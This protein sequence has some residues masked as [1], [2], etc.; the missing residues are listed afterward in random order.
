MNSGAKSEIH[1]QLVVQRTRV[2]IGN[3]M[4]L[5]LRGKL[6]K[7]GISPFKVKVP[8]SLSKRTIWYKRLVVA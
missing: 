1:W 2:V 8:T 5:G 4:L 7:W 3:G 6:C